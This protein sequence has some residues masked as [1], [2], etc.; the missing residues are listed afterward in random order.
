[1]YIPYFLYS[2]IHW[3]S[4]GLYSF[5]ASVYSAPVNKGPWYQGNVD[6]NHNEISP[7]ICYDSYYFKTPNKQQ[8]RFGEH[9]EKFEPLRTVG[10]DVGGAATMGN[11][12]EVPQKIKDRITIWSSNPSGYIFRTLFSYLIFHYVLSSLFV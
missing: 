2:F 12:V 5:L 4:F 3:W 7:Y 6:Q 8:R 10:G 11:C 9:V 1:M